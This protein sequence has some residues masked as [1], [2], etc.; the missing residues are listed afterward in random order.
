MF[1]CYSW[2]LVN[3]TEENIKEWIKEAVL[4]IEKRNR[5]FPTFPSL[6]HKSA[7]FLDK[8]L[9]SNMALLVA[10]LTLATARPTLIALSSARLRSCT[11]KVGYNLKANKKWKGCCTWKGWEFGRQMSVALG[12]ILLVSW[13]PFSGASLRVTLFSSS[14]ESE[15]ER[16]RSNSITTIRPSV[17]SRKRKEGFLC[18]FLTFHFLKPCRSSSVK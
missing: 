1:H 5:E 12:T 18:C 3:K 11:Q 9:Q 8:T 10:G 4:F 17:E 15:T 7:W 16:G 6:Y 14:A 2:Y 13:P